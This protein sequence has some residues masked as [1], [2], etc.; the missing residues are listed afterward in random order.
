MNMEK[1]RFAIAASLALLPMM[2]CAPALAHPAHADGL[3]SGFAHP[4]LGLDHLLAAAAAGLWAVQIGGRRLWA[5]PLA[6]IAALL[7]GGLLGLGGSL[8]PAMVAAVEPMVAASVLVLGLMVMLRARPD[9]RWQGA[10]LALTGIFALFHGYA[11]VAGLPVNATVGG[12]LLG[13]VAA[14]VV[15]LGAGMLA[16]RN[17][18]ALALRSAGVPIALAGGWLTFGAL[19][20]T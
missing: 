20:G 16:G 4:L 2:A 12:Y 7:A 6:F 11:H 10:D 17:L 9:G 14:T 13:F 5:V 15:L 8:M 3:A 19:I 18:R 1:R